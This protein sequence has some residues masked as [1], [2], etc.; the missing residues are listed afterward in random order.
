MGN[1]AKVAIIPAYEPKENILEL[2]KELKKE[3]LNIIVVDDGSGKKF[4]KIFQ[5]SEM[6]A[7][8]LHHPKNYGKGRAIKTALKYVKEN[9][10]TD[11]VIVTL[12]CDG[13]HTVNDVKKIYNEVLKN[14][15][16]LVIGK[17]I[18]SNKTPLRSKLGNSI[19]RFIYYLVTGTSIYD[20]QTGLRG[21]SKKHIDF[22]LNVNGERYEYE[23]NV[24]LECSRNNIPIKEI[25][26]ET[27]YFDNNSNSHFNTIKDSMRIYKQI[28]KFSSSSLISFIIDYIL[29]TI[30]NIILNNIIIANILARC[31]SATVNYSINKKLVFLSKGKVL[32]S[33]FQYFLL[34][35]SILVL[36]TLILN[37]FT[38]YLF[39]NEYIAKIIT[40]IILFLTSWFIQKK[41]IFKKEQ[42]IQ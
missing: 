22:M 41:I 4:E 15:N 40:E 9:Y 36:N 30:F 19:T 10:S 8:V 3:D 11:Y 39:I 5:F 16:E 20:T 32:K 13:Q 31:I 12:D 2:L 21:F 24:L 42:Q 6:Y 27:I 14:P 17:R 34:A 7:T 25:V 28:I 18:R 29:Y 35:V 1:I 33:A 26:I 37:F 23:I 38:R